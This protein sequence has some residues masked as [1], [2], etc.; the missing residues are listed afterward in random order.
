METAGKGLENWF[1]FYYYLF[2]YFL[3]CEIHHTVYWEILMQWLRYPV[4]S[5]SSQ[6]DFSAVYPTGTTSCWWNTLCLMETVAGG[7]LGCEGMSESFSAFRD[8]FCLKV[9]HFHRNNS[10]WGNS[11]SQKSILQQYSFDENVFYVVVINNAV[12]WIIPT[13][14]LVMRKTQV[15]E[16]S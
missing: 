6:R 15:L 1:F 5:V 12:L 16:T 11:I 4:L 2:I 8:Y 7:G 14:W 9:V 3:F 13:R 10:V